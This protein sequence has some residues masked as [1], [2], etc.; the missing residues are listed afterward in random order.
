MVRFRGSQIDSKFN[1][2]LILDR[3]VSSLAAARV[4]AIVIRLEN[5]NSR[6]SKYCQ[7]IP[8]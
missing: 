2:A 8:V 7:P 5:E 4:R 3:I 6:E 1:M